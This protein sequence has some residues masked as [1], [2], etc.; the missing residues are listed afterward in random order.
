MGLVPAAREA[1]SVLLSAIFGSALD[2]CTGMCLGTA[3]TCGCA[4][5]PS[6]LDGTMCP[7]GTPLPSSEMLVGDKHL[8]RDV[9]KCH[10]SLVPRV[11]V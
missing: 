3:Q 7:S 10:R 5:S 11:P 6:H 4:S 8:F 1:E 2:G 9:A